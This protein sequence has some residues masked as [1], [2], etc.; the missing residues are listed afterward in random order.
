M[1]IKKLII[2]MVA[3]M[4]PVTHTVASDWE[5]KLCWDVDIHMNFAIPDNDSITSYNYSDKKYDE[6]TCPGYIWYNTKLLRLDLSHNSFTTLPRLVGNLTSLQCLYL[7]DNKLTCLPDEITECKE[8]RLLD[9]SNNPTLNTL[10][11]GIAD[12]PITYLNLTGTSVAVLPVRMVDRVKERMLRIEG[13]AGDF[14][15]PSLTPQKSKC[16]VIN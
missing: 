3:C 16:C 5:D 6:K 11:L 10:P 1:K 12:L 7:N 9:L 15:I 4:F 14:F 13:F 8:L 2:V